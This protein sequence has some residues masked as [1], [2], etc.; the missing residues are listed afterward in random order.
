[1]KSVTGLSD[2]EL[3]ALSDR[4]AKE[5]FMCPLIAFDLIAG[6]KYKLRTLWTLRNGKR[7]YGEIRR[8]LVVGR[9]GKPITPRVL[10]RELKELAG[11]QL[12]VRT[13]YAGVPPRVEYELTELGLSL[14]PIIDS[15]LAWGMTGAQVR[16]LPEAGPA[17]P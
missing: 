11:R 5:G 13:E 16:I 3:Q 17:T 10:S 2:A 12:V 6:G 7:R 9:Q 4:K 1:M 8:S 14:L 15:V